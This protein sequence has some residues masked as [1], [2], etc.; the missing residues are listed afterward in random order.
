MNKTYVIHW[1]SRS[2]GRMGTGTTRFGRDEADRLAKELNHDYP[3]IEHRVLDVASDSK[4]EPLP[5]SF[6]NSTAE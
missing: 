3:E 2:N 6:A 5:V 1:K 4:P